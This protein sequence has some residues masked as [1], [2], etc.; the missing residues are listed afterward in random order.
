[1]YNV[2]IARNYAHAKHGQIGKVNLIAVAEIEI[3]GESLP[4]NS[5]RAIL[6]HGLQILQDAYAGAKDRPAAVKA[7]SEKLTKLLE[8]KLGTRN[9]SDPVESKMWEL[10]EKAFRGKG[11]KGKELEAAVEAFMA[12]EENTAKLRPLAEKALSNETDLLAGL[13]D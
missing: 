8:G 12:K 13:S 4:E 5:V 10:C 11:L 7:F 3:N 6:N 9:S 2:E 1:M